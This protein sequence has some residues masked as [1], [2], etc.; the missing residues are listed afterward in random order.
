M[1][2]EELGRGRRVEGGGCCRRRGGR[3]WG[4]WALAAVVG[5]E[6]VVVARI[7]VVGCIVEVV[8]VGSWVAGRGVGLV[9]VHKV[10]YGG[11][12][13][14][15]GREVGSGSAVLYETEAVKVVEEQTHS[16]GYFGV[17]ARWRCTDHGEGWVA[18]LPVG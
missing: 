14:A 18:E 17:D 3:G 13:L 4:L 11:G 2:W 1:G 16:G 6:V 12:V 10:R 15:E 7:G 9:V 5:W 8:E